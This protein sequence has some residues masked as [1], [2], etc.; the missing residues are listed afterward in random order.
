MNGI[1][2]RNR[3]GFKF[4]I[5]IELFVQEAFNKKVGL[6]NNILVN[7]TKVMELAKGRV[8]L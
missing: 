5:K 7:L 2:P 6:N 4:K 3:V 1:G 8:I